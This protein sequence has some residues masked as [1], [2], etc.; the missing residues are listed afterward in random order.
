MGAVTMSTLR[1][2]TK[3]Y[4]YIPLAIVVLLEIGLVYLAGGFFV[5]LFQMGVI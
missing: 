5:Q 1:G 4:H 3:P 2:L